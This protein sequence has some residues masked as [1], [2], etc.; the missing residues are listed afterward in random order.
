M[1]EV[2]LTGLSKHYGDFAAAS[3]VSFDV[4]SGSF[5]SLLGPSGCG[6]TTTL[7]MIIGFEQPTAGDIFIDGERINDIKPWLRDLGVVFQNYAL[8]PYM[9]VAEN[10]AFGLKQRGVEPAEIKRRASKF[11]E[12]VGL[13]G[14]EDRFPRQLSGGQQQRVALARA[15]V[16][17]PRVLLLDEPLSNLDAKLR[18]E[19]RFELKR[20]QNETGVTSV[21]VTH[22]QEEALTLSDRIVVMNHGEVVTVGK[23][24]E[25]WERPT[26]AFVA[27]F[28][29]VENIFAPDGFEPGAVVIGGKR[30]AAEHDGQGNRLVGLRSTDIEIGGDADAGLAGRVQQTSYRGSINTYVV[31]VPGIAR[32]LYISTATDLPIGS[33]IVLKPRDGAVLILDPDMEIAAA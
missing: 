27:D 24:K 16:I 4:E 14:K 20:I 12:L 5:L 23:P 9:T 21:F 28:L 7:R 2:K 10:V 13:P 31:D 29:G 26:S 22:D 1:A 30:F 19:M 33:N 3:N 18:A 11:L 8:F 15:L 6:K 32:P 25:I 17:E